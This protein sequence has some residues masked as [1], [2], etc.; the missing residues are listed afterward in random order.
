MPALPSLVAPAAVPATMEAATAVETASTVESAAT[1]TAIKATA[2]A[3]PAVKTTIKETIPVPKAAP[4][5]EEGSLAKPMKPRT[6][7]DEDAAHKRIRSVV[8]IGRAGV[9]V[10]VVV[11]VGADRRWA[12]V[13]RGAVIGGADSDAHNHALGVRVRRRE[14]T[15]SETN[16]E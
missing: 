14:E 6:C 7:A 1:K 10:V 16:A 2:K 11:A 8:A 3:T 4:K 13:I 15:K 5:A 9:W 12:V